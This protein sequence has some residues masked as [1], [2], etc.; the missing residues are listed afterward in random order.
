[1]TIYYCPHQSVRDDANLQPASA[2]FTLLA[3]SCTMFGDL[4]QSAM[5]INYPVARIQAEVYYSPK[6][7]QT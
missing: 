4:G 3:F 5:T 2:R 1:M 7:R 6:W